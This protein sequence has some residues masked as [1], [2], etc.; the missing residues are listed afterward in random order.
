MTRRN[1]ASQ[2]EETTMET[3][4][5]LD[6]ESASKDAFF[7]RIAALSEEMISAHGEEF[8]MGALILGARWIADRQGKPGAKPS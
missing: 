7:T 6:P 4:V 8:A 5:K 3:D 1:A 2:A